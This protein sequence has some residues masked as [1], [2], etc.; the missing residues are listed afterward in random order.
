MLS[1]SVTAVQRDCYGS[2]LCLVPKLALVLTEC[3]EV[4]ACCLRTWHGKWGP[5]AAPPPP[6]CNGGSHAGT[7]AV[8][9]MSQDS[10]YTGGRPQHSLYTGGISCHITTKCLHRYQHVQ[11][12]SLSHHNT[13]LTEVAVPVTSQ[14]IIYNITVTSQNIIYKVAVPVTS[15]NIIY[16]VAVPV[17]SQNIIYKVAVPATSQHSTCSM[18]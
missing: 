13:A 12:R 17:T 14:N 5:P 1:K 16:K 11:H 15:Q 9:V 4:A 18:T 8:P 3:W 6:C 2:Q 7:L 10:I